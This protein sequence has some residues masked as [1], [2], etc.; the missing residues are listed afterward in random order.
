MSKVLRS[1]DSDCN[2][3][4]MAFEESMDMSS[5]TFDELMWSLLAH[6][7]KLKKDEA[8]KEEEKGF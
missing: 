1:L 5:Y 7:V 4:V 3:V 8:G 2:H 6:E